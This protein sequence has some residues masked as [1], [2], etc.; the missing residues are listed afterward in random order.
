MLRRKRKSR[1]PPWQVRLVAE[2]FVKLND[3]VKAR[4]LLAV[5]RPTVTRNTQEMIVA[6][7]KTL[8]TSYHEPNDF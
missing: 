1:Y 3:I 2:H 7:A 8:C 5:D 6:G 4:S